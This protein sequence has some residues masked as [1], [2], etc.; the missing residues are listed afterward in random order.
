MRLDKLDPR[1]VENGQLKGVLT[2][3]DVGRV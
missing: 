2:P 3:K 1:S